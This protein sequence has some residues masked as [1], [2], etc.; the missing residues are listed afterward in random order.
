MPTKKFLLALVLVVCA[1]GAWP[2]YRPTVPTQAKEVDAAKLALLHS[3]LTK[4]Q[5]RIRSLLIVRNSQL[6]F[7]YHRVGLDRDTLHEVASVTKSVVGILAGIAL[8]R[9]QLK[10]LDQPLTEIF[11]ELDTSAA[12]I[13]LRDLLT[14]SSGFD[15]S[16]VPE[17][18]D[19]SAF[20]AQFVQGQA[21]P[22]ALAR[23]VAASPGKT[24]YYSNA[25]AHLVSV[26]IA[27]AVRQPLDTFAQAALFKPL[28]IANT[29]WGANAQG[30]VN[31][32]SSLRLTSHA[33]AKLG[34][35]ML[36]QG[37]WDGQQIVSAEYVAQSTRAHLP[38]PYPGQG[39]GFLW[40]TAVTPEDSLPA[41]F[42]IGF[43]GQYI[44]VVPQ[45]AL[46]VV[47]VSDP[48]DLAD[49]SGAVRTGAVLRNYVLPAIVR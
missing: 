36:Q 1:G 18:Q 3:H 31:G 40:R 4:Q 46:V 2:Q 19:Y 16:A 30:E 6:Q 21:A 23:R 35:L 28:D 42:A 17:S 38:L 44:Y 13:R 22:M 5:T 7:E 29:Y 41:F 14:L 39:Y 15:H 32:A 43:G 10:S 27:R 33:M 11:S 20:Y 45:L 48:F 49:Q 26:A 12:H 9:G 37:R 24:W 25:D 8:D 47:A 34:Q